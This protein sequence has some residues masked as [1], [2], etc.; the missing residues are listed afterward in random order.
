MVSKNQ[1]LSYLMMLV[2]SAVV[3]NIVEN[4]FIPPLQ[5]GLRLGLANIVALIV[6][7]LF[8][9]KALFAVNILR[10]IIASLFN[11][12]I[13]NVAFWLSFTGVIF[14]SITI[15]LAQVFRSS[16]LFTSLLSS[17]AHSFG[18]LFAIVVIYKDIHIL[19]LI[20]VLVITSLITGFITYT[21]ADKV[22]ER[23]KRK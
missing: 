13:F 1:R 14:S 16:L 7:S 5:F 20:P 19:Y 3:I 8:D 4:L 18:Q 22:L 12:V 11:G 21:I 17:L 6:A 15:S 9:I 23:L 2:A 10:V